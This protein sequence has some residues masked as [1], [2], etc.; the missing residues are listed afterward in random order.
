[1]EKIKNK[2]LIS[3]SVVSHGQQDLISNLFHD[4][5]TYCFPVTFEVILTLNL[6]EPLLFTQN[7]FPF[8]LAVIRNTKAKGFAENHNQAFEQATGAFFCVLNPDIRLTSDP[9]PTL[10][11]CLKNNVG[12]TAPLV[13]NQSGTAED[14]ARYFPTPFK[15]IR[16]AFGGCKGSDYLINNDILFPDWVAGMFMLFPAQ[17]FRKIGG[18]DTGFFLYYEDVDLC[19]RLRLQGYEIVLCPTAQIIH[20]AQRSSHRSL[21]YLKWHLTSMMRFFCSAVFLKILWRKLIKK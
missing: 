18:F 3:I 7:K 2:I 19:A 11:S 16:K 20:Q 9:F 15:I 13:L 14:S 10:L 1:M 21:K 6:N 8:P 12:I 4:L 17:I 5:A